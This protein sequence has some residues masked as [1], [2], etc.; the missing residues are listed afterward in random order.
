M[1]VL[2]AIGE[3]NPFIAAGGLGKVA[4]SF[5]RSIRE[6]LINCRLVIPLYS[7]I[8][9]SM[10]SKMKYI[11]NISVPV[12][13]RQQYCGIF[14]AHVNG[15]IYYFIDNEYYFKRSGIYGHYDD[16][17]RFAFFSRA[18]LEMLRFINYPPDILHCNDWQTALIPVYRK[19]LYGEMEEYKNIKTVFTIHNLLYQGQF[20]K[21]VFPDILGLNSWDLPVL[22]FNGCI[23]LMKGAVETADAVTTV[24][25]SYA[26]EIMEPCYGNGLDKILRNNSSKITGITNG[27]DTQMY[28]PETDDSILKNYSCNDISGKAMNK[29]ALQK[30]FNL[31]V[32]ETIPVIGMV[33]R[34][35]D[36]KGLDLVR[37]VIEEILCSRIQMVLLGTG[38]A[39]NETF[40]LDI[41]G[42][43]PGKMAIKIGYFPDIA[44]KIYAGADMLLKPSKSEICGLSQMAALR[45]GT[46]PI[47]RETGGL[48][49]TVIDYENGT[50]NGFAF[51]TYNPHAML[52]AIRRAEEL[53]Y[54]K[55]EWEK[56]IKRALSCDFCWQNSAEKYL[57]LYKQ[58]LNQE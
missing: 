30:L 54:N 17:E 52:N 53:F 25:R 8:P 7:D 28:D 38:D 9:D 34:L 32:E 58:L 42:R 50:G 10:R 41:A 37:A 14:E 46:I 2:Y 56:L 48:K 57:Q 26:R 16:G 27:I 47:V 29:T 43:Y 1:N 6:K 15:T 22:E 23:N 4:A 40:F 20:G 11:A 36:Q 49:D 5:T 12:G 13:W 55:Q 24:S 39:L 31:P 45:Y 33:T 44:R 21:D 51:K 3:A 19:L 18:V 35:V